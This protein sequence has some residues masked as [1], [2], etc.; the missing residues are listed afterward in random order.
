MDDNFGEGRQPPHSAPAK[1]GDGASQDL[2]NLTG[3]TFAGATDMYSTAGP[4]DT[5]PGT[6]ATTGID[7]RPGSVLPIERIGELQALNGDDGTLS[8]SSSARHSRLLMEAEIRAEHQAAAR[9]TMLDLAHALDE[10]NRQKRELAAQLRAEYDANASLRIDRDR[11][12]AEVDRL[13]EMEEKRQ[14][15]VLLDKAK[16]SGNNVMFGMLLEKSRDVYD[17][18]L[19]DPDKSKTAALKEMKEDKG[20]IDLA[21]VIDG[22]VGDK[23]TMSWVVK[24]WWHE[25]ELTRE[26][27]RQAAEDEER[28]RREQAERDRIAGEFQKKIDALLKEKA[29]LEA[30][31]ERARKRIEELEKAQEKLEKELREAKEQAARD[32]AAAKAREEALKEEILQMR[33]ELSETK[34][35]LAELQQQYEEAQEALRKADE[36]F[37]AERSR[38]KAIIKQVQSELHE[39]L[40]LAKHMR[41]TALK[42]KRDAAGSVSP[43]K[44]AELIAQLEEMKNQLSV[45]SKDNANEKDN[46]AW[47]NG[48]LNKNKRQLELERQFLP[49]LRKVRG[50][51]GPKAKGGQ[52]EEGVKRSRDATQLANQGAPNSMPALP[53]PGASPNKLQM[54][55]SMGALTQGRAS[56][57]GGPLQG[58]RGGSDPFA[59]SLGFASSNGQGTPMRG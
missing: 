9:N 40:V 34:S 30:E 55:Q 50:P 20:S 31:V 52:G 37:A 58:T 29:K 13:E 46:N 22:A 54:S 3:T 39:A 53:A 5:R 35:A 51:V 23:V 10:S 36:A 26:R 47:L 42:A 18:S 27:N 19:F 33:K 15:Q 38:L 4:N 21:N 17:F 24:L 57:A 11:L 59:S 16:K 1:P 7:T 44:F 48:Q 6:E 45:L 12:Q 32:A 25:V 14:A 8:V 56:T 41:E 43:Q 2:F 28:L 49:L